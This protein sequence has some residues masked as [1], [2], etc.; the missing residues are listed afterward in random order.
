M[1]D[2]WISDIRHFLDEDGLIPIDL[3]GPALRLA[4]HFGS[5]VK[6]VS[7]H[8]GIEKKHTG[9]MC[10]RRP[11][12]KP[13]PGEIIAKIDNQ[14]D[15]AIHWYCTICNDNGIISGWQGTIFDHST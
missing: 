15:Y 10:R 5:I 6:A 9:I 3:P 11:G 7:S 2:R 14:N 8:K 1:G 13:C 12:H 4:K